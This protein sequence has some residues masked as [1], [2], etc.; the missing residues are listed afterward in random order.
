MGCMRMRPACLCPGFGAPWGL[1]SLHRP[2]C[3]SA[4]GAV[5]SRSLAQGAA[6]QRPPHHCLSPTG[7]PLSSPGRRG[8]SCRVRALHF[9]PSAWHLW[10]TIHWEQRAGPGH[11]A[12]GG[13]RLRSW[14][15]KAEGPRWGPAMSS[16]GLAQGSRG[17]CP[18]KPAP[19]WPR[20]LPSAPPEPLGSAW[21]LG[22]ARS[23]HRPSPLAP[24]TLL[25][26]HVSGMEK[27]P[28]LEDGPLLPHPGEGTSRSWNVKGNNSVQGGGRRARRVWAR[29]DGALWWPGAELRSPAP[30]CAGRTGWRRKVP[31][32]L[33]RNIQE[34]LAAPG[35]GAPDERD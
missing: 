1:R 27:G 20:A 5:C 13:G 6:P 33:C 16:A 15:R 19:P 22:G 18:E 4:R 11:T 12:G 34:H 7:W 9:A 30:A 35:P 8:S 3:L 31:S 17:C 2:A 14:S 26:V 21:A 32:P 24:I 10:Q 23:P 29:R 25:C 28:G